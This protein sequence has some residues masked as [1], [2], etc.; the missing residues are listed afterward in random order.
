MTIDAHAN[1]FAGN[2]E[3]RWYFVRTG[4]GTRLR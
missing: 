1:V 4:R 3:G 2:A